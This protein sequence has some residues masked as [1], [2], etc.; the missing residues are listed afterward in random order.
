MILISPPLPGSCAKDAALGQG[1]QSLPALLSVP[2]NAGWRTSPKRLLSVAQWFVLI[3]TR[4][5]SLL[6]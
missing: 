3:E 5:M 2:Q 1:E 4:Q 6:L